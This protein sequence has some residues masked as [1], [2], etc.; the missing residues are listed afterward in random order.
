[1]CQ[2]LPPLRRVVVQRGLHRRFLRLSVP[3]IYPYTLDRESQSSRCAC[4]QPNL[5]HDS[6]GDVPLTGMVLPEPRR[7]LTGSLSQL[8]VG[9]T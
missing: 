9:Y 3:Y 7:T 4:E 1:M 2:P 6:R 5:S 8:L